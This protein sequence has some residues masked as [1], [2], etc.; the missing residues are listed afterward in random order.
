MFELKTLKVAIIHDWLISYRGGEKV[1]ESICEL[2]PDA[3]IYT[4]FYDKKN[5]PDSLTSKNIIYPRGLNSF[6]LIRKFLLPL[7]PQFIEEFDLRGYDLIISSSSCVAK[8]IIPD[9]SAKHICYIHSPMRYIW[10]QRSFYFSSLAKLPFLNFLLSLFLK[11]LRLWDTAS[12]QRV[13]LFLSNSSFVQKRVKRYYRRDSEVIFPSPDMDK[14]KISLNKNF[15]QKENYFLVLG[16]LVPYKNF[17][18]AIKAFNQTNKTLWVVGKGSEFKRLKKLAK[19][20]IVFKGHLPNDEV[21]K[22]L[23]GA[24]ALIFPGTEDFG[25]TAIES[26]TLGTPVIANKSGG[27]LDF[28]EEGKNG[29]F[30]EEKTTESLLEAIA[31]YEKLEFKKD[32]IKET[33]LRFS[34]ENFQNSF[35]NCIEKLMKES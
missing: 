13:D 6:R 17:E 16:A 24:Q 32:T 14:T 5:L 29:I 11:N 20:N 19:T 35:R 33:S 30:F 18:L 8:G 26:F 25:L 7:L 1:L 9:P 28:I 15:L 12:N 2:Y 10:D 31:K 22:A 23:A 4:L 27:A 21:Y 34:K 3:P